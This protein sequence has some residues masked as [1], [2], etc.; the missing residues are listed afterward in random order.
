MSTP[1]AGGSTALPPAVHRERS[2]FT[3]MSTAQAGRL[4][5]KAKLS[6]NRSAADIYGVIAGLEAAGDR[7]TADAVRVNRA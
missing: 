5:A 6:Q 7:T 2:S 3:G 1:W 4:D